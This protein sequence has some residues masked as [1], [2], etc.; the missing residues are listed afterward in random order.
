MVYF[1][2]RR[3]LLLISRF[4]HCLHLTLFLILLLFDSLV[5]PILNYSSE[6]QGFHNVND[7]VNNHSNFL[8]QTLGVHS[9]TSNPTINGEFARFPLSVIRNN[10]II[11]YWYKINRNPSSLMYKCTYLKDN[12]GTLINTWSKNVISLL[13]SLGYAYIWKNVNV[14]GEI[15]NDIVQ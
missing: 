1:I 15:L 10:P 13:S 12:H 14:S 2:K 3:K 7:V 8:K 11:R 4:S 6:V 9:K 5:A